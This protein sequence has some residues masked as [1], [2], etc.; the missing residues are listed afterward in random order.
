MLAVRR[1]IQKHLQEVNR[2]KD[3]ACSKLGPFRYRDRKQITQRRLKD[4]SKSEKW[5]LRDDQV[6]QTMPSERSHENAVQPPPAV[7]TVKAA[8]AQVGAQGVEIAE[9]QQDN[10][11]EDRHADLDED[12]DDPDEDDHYG[13]EQVFDD[14]DEYQMDSGDDE[15]VL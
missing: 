6:F 2:T 13:R 3:R 8:E 7:A 12:E 15:A 9:V 5:E 14:D 4:A 1:R 11:G 10:P